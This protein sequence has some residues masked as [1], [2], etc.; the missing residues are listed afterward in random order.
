MSP[1]RVLPSSRS[2][3]HRSAHWLCESPLAIAI[4]T[5]RNELVRPVEIRSTYI[6]E[7]DIVFKISGYHHIER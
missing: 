7:M 4:A 5:R 6:D 2:T 3:A 1:V